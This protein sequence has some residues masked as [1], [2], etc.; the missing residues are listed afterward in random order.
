MFDKPQL[1]ELCRLVI[2]AAAGE[3]MSRFDS[4]RA[5]LKADGS[6]ITAADL[7][8]QERLQRELAARWPR[9]ELL[10]EEMTA[11]DQKCLLDSDC[12]GLWCLD[13]L[14]GTSNFAAGI[15]FFGVSLALIIDGSAHAA[16]VYDP[17]RDECFSAL[18]GAGA[19]LNGSGL[20][21]P[22]SP[23]TLREAMAMVDLKRLPPALVRAVAERSPYRSQRSFGSVALDWCWVA[24]GRCQVYLHGGQKLWDYAAGELILREAGAAGG[25]LDDYFGDWLDSYAL[26]PRI[27]IAASHVALLDLWRDWIGQQLR[28]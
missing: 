19:W 16:V 24:C 4:V 23:A 6:L 28:A 18:K 12:D 2:D 22:H 13:P 15:P 26:T 11:A 21:A 17:A 14:D 3:L 1:E 10:G 5:E 20:R 7:A 9:Y 25:L 27:A 8:M